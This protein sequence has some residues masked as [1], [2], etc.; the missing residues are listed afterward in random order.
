MPAPRGRWVQLPGACAFPTSKGLPGPWPP[1]DVTAGE[2]FCLF[3]VH[4]ALPCSGEL[5]G[6]SQRPVGTRLFTSI[7]SL[8][9]SEALALANRLSQKLIIVRELGTSPPEVRAG[10]RGAGVLPLCVCTRTRTRTHLHGSS[11]TRNGNFLWRLAG[12]AAPLPHRPDSLR[13][14]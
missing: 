12:Q 13:S 2:V 9:G 5:V 1:P 10:L 8:E 7:F 3:V 6:L 14:V 11:P 4:W